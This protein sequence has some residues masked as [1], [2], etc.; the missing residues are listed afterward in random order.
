MRNQK[1]VLYNSLSRSSIATRVRA[2][3]AGRAL[4]LWLVVGGL[5]LSA[6]MAIRSTG[7]HHE[8]D[9]THLQIARWVWQYPAYLLDD[10]GR[11]GFTALYAIPAGLGWLPARLFSGILTAVTAWMA[12]LIAA[13]LRVRLAVLVPLLFWL[14]PLVF[15]LSYTTL[16]ETALAFYLALAMWLYV[17]GRFACSAAAISLCAV[18]RHEGGLFLV[19][20]LIA[21]L[22]RA[23]PAREWLWIL[24]APLLHNVLARVFLHE[25]P[26]LL[27]LHPHPTSEYGHGTLLTMLALWPLAAGFGPLLLALVGAPVVAHRRGGL[28]LVSSAAVYFLAHS[29]LYG[30]GLFGSGGYARFLVPVGPMVAVCAAQGLSR[31]QRAWERWQTAPR[32]SGLFKMSAIGAAAVLA[33]WLASGLELHRLRPDLIINRLLWTVPVLHA[34]ALL[35]ALLFLAA[36]A[37]SSAPRMARPA[38]A[39]IAL[40]AT[41]L[42]AAFL[43][44][45]VVS[46]IPPP[47]RQCAP[48]RLTDRERAYRMAADV[49]L[50]FLA[51]GARVFSAS[52]WVDEFTGRVRPPAEPDLRERWKSAK[53]GDVLIWDGREAASPRHR[54]PLASLTADPGLV[55]IW[56]STGDAYDPVYC[57]VFRK[58][59]QREPPR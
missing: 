56:R 49:A 54:L 34:T 12:Y 27:L 21:L 24:W 9:L 32:H 6:A 44:P 39:L 7:V 11:P 43:Q 22:Y 48:L 45:L 37:F 14:Q 58:K 19:L 15:T 17:R 25:W 13:Q 28:L 29:I 41:A 1:R 33:L 31:Y 57:A 51:D 5:L 40:P 52:P 53:P 4:A 42:A 47:S 2:R 10:W 3:P 26:L 36:W 30:C 16:T 35:L 20:W 18:T 23:R 46:V 38:M 55:E 50:P 8:D 59:P